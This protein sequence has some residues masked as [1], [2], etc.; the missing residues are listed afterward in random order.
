M[1]PIITP[2]QKL[3]QEKTNSSLIKQEQQLDVEMDDIQS[4]LQNKRFSEEAEN[5]PISNK[6]TVEHRYHYRCLLYT[7]RCV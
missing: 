1:K 7:S 2:L 5:I 4:R 3:V 6:R